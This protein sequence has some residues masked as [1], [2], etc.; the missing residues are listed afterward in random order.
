MSSM[1]VDI[2]YSPSGCFWKHVCSQTLY[3]YLVKSE[4]RVKAIGMWLVYCG[5]LSGV[6]WRRLLGIQWTYRAAHSSYSGSLHQA[7]TERWLTQQSGTRTHFSKVDINRGQTG[8]SNRAIKS[9]LSVMC[10][11]YKLVPPLQEW[12][13]GWGRKMSRNKFKILFT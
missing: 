1:D 3:L 10:R 4:I 8:S 12:M 7:M 6:I 11:Q 5:T 9:I 13:E 2:Q